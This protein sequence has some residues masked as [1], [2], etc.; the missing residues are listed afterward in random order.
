MKEF[1]NLSP[2]VSIILPTYNRALC[3]ERAV[4]SVICQTLSNWELIIIDNNS[5]DNTVELI[6][7]FKDVRISITKIENNG[8][9]ARSR[10]LGI[11]LASGTFVAFL[12][13]DDWWVPEKLEIAVSALQDGHDVVYHDMYMINLVLS[14]CKFKI[15]SH[16]K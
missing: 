4:S 16:L 5:T 8:I 14:C 11:S 7:N 2:L 12:D 9:V 15:S 1:T 6:D 10:N 3:I 13:S